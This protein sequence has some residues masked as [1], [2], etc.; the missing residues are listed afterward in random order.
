MAE[1]LLECEPVRNI[2]VFHP[3]QLRR[4]PFGHRMQSSNR[5]GGPLSVW[6]VEHLALHPGKDVHGISVVHSV[7]HLTGCISSW[8]ENKLQ[9]RN[10]LQPARGSQ[11]LP[12]RGEVL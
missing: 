8:T 5:L 2:K 12:Q 7:H 1:R 3:H 10:G 4:N 9:L 6:I 11:S